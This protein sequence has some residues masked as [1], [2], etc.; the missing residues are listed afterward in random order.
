MPT[1]FKRC[2]MIGAIS[3]LTGCAGLESSYDKSQTQTYKPTLTPSQSPTR[4]LNTSTYLALE[5]AY[6]KWLDEHNIGSQHAKVLIEHAQRYLQPIAQMQD[7]YEADF[8]FP[9]D[10][11]PPSVHS[12]LYVGTLHHTHACKVQKPS[13]NAYKLTLDDHQRFHQFLVDQ[14]IW[15][16]NAY[17]LA[18][19]AVRRFASDDTIPTAVLC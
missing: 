4:K 5:N 19:A 18:Q 2:L 17:E 7:G 15:T 9:I 14:N 10:F 8:E 11:E 12:A 6:E 1:N 13:N 16:L 3:L